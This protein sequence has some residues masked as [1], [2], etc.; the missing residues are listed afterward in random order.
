MNV[1]LL[2]AR[3]ET[4]PGPTFAWVYFQECIHQLQHRI[5]N[6]NPP[7]TNMLP[8]FHS[9]KFQMIKYYIGI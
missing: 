9:S 5:L 7:H 3:P 2:Q 8:G 1:G 4:R 6:V